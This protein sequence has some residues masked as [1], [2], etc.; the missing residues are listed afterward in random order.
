[1]PIR[2]VSRSIVALATIS[3]PGN[4]TVRHKQH[5]TAC[6]LWNNHSPQTFMEGFQMALY[7]KLL[8][9]RYHALPRS[10]KAVIVVAALVVLFF[11]AL[12]FGEQLGRMLYSLTH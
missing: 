3:L 10:T 5:D 8:A 2:Y 1:V 4:A 11:N 7:T 9:R 12:R 6:F